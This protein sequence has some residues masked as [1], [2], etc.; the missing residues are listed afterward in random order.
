[1]DRCYKSYIPPVAEV[2]IP[3]L[4]SE[5]MATSMILPQDAKWE[6]EVDI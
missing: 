3:A 2:V 5:V 4:G 6:T 1:M